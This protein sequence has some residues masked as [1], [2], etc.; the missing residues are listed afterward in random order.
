M[1]GKKVQFILLSVKSKV[2]S[3]NFISLEFEAKLN[4]MVTSK[5][6]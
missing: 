3:F 4:M 5:S 2:L 6:K 1:N